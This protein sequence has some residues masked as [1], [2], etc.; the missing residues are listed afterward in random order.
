MFTWL[1]V[2]ALFATTTYFD[3]PKVENLISWGVTAVEFVEL[4]EIQKA[5]NNFQD[6]A[7]AYDEFGNL[8]TLTQVGDTQIEFIQRATFKTRHV[9]TG[10]LMTKRS[11]FEIELANLFTN[12]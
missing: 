7:T 5:S 1:I 3:L 2:T 8:A 11:E 4:L 9:L 10:V 6:E 12:G